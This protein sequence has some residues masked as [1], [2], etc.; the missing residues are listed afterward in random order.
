VGIPADFGK[1]PKIRLQDEVSVQALVQAAL[2]IRSPETNCGGVVD[3]GEQ[4]SKTM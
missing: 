2:D 3:V 1:P 4:L